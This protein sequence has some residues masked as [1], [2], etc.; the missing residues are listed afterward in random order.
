MKEKHH[1]F[2]VSYQ[3]KETVDMSN[4]NLA[5]PGATGEEVIGGSGLNLLVSF[6]M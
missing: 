4:S 6:C 3:L 5:S 1:Q 2:L